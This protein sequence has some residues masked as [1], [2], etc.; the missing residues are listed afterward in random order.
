MKKIFNF[1]LLAVA[2]TLVLVSVTS[3]GKKS[4]KETYPIPR[5]DENFKLITKTYDILNYN[6][7]YIG[8]ACD[9][10]PSKQLCTVIDIVQEYLSD[11]QVR[12]LT[13]FVQVLSPQTINFSMNLPEMLILNIYFNK[14][15]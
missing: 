14:T 2:M 1:L 6:L 10:L 11:D 4:N 5:L 7:K 13:D 3:C 12:P 9:Y 15:F 8:I